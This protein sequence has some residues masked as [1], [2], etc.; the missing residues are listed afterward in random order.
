LQ[1]K[2]VSPTCAQVNGANV[3]A[4]E[5]T[6]WNLNA[7]PGYLQC[8]ELGLC[9]WLDPAGLSVGSF[10]FTNGGGNPESEAGQQAEEE[11]GKVADLPAAV[12][13]R[14]MAARVIPYAAP[15]GMNAAERLAHNEAQ[16]RQ[17]MSEGRQ[18][19]DMGPGKMTSPSSA[20]AMEHA[21]IFGRNYGNYVIHW[22]DEIS[23]D[24]IEA[25]G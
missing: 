14:G 10:L 17:W 22:I 1:V 12:I 18:I 11:A 6:S 5:R 25:M 3:G 23:S 8:L 15:A 13:G 7:D 16:I 4:C 19:I 21:T 2:L 9:E 24:V 20:Y